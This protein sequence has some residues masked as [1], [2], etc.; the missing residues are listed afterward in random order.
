MVN[1][2]GS[3]E[4]RD[5]ATASNSHEDQTCARNS[6]A[7]ER[8]T[9]ETSDVSCTLRNMDPAHKTSTCLHIMLSAEEME[10]LAQKFSP[11]GCMFDITSEEYF[12][13]LVTE[14]VDSCTFWANIDD[15]VR[16]GVCCSMVMSSARVATFSLLSVER[17]KLKYKCYPG[18]VGKVL[19]FT[20]GKW[21]VIRTRWTDSWPGRKMEEWLSFDSQSLCTIYL[22]VM[23]NPF[24][25]KSDQLQISPTASPGILHHTVW[26]IWIFIAYSDERWL[27][28]QF[29]LNRSHLTFLF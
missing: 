16:C 27:Y 24:T 8:S 5:I 10:Q 23:I 15:K 6:P 26:R 11:R 18:D 3:P 29:W 17:Y 20:R 21:A 12:D 19:Q 7:G 22:L 13:V 1:Q 4:A 25:H 28:Y 2:S 9:M 14:V